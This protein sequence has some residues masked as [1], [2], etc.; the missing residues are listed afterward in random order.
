MRS[1][2][3]GLGE[4]GKSPYLHATGFKITVLASVSRYFRDLSLKEFY[5]AN[6]FGY[7]IRGKD[8]NALSD[9]LMLHLTLFGLP[10]PFNDK[11]STPHGQEGTDGAISVPSLYI[12]NL[13]VHL[14]ARLRLGRRRTIMFDTAEA[15]RQLERCVVKYSQVWRPQLKGHQLLHS[16]CKII[17]C[18][19]SHRQE[20][21]QTAWDTKTLMTDLFLTER[22]RTVRT[23]HTYD[24]LR[25]LRPRNKGRRRICLGPDKSP[26]VIDRE[27]VTTSKWIT[28]KLDR[29]S[30]NDASTTPQLE[31]MGDGKSVSVYVAVH[32]GK[33]P[34][35]RLPEFFDAYKL[36]DYLVD[37]HAENIIMNSIIMLGSDRR[38]IDGIDVD[39][40]MKCMST[41]SFGEY[42]RELVENARLRGSDKPLMLID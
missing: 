12:R 39:Y 16:L 6:T 11:D 21:S 19:Y 13:H 40:V 26:R 29:W 31:V 30:G 22:T 2:V 38:S 25:Q 27:L 28:A 15:T 5:R 4:Y 41:I 14:P 8:D 18:T 34:S 33:T 36:A 35:A 42:E 9:A 32:H 24:I 37:E 7:E 3:V 23:T 17:L 20:I 1:G 10:A